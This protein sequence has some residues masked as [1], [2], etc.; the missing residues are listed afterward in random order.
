MRHSAR[1]GRGCF[2]VVSRD[3]NSSDALQSVQETLIL[4]ALQV[5]FHFNPNHRAYPDHRSMALF[6]STINPRIWQY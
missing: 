2:N 1:K 3:F 5:L 6:C 4:V